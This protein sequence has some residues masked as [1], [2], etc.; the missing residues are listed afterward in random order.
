M[1]A[2]L[3]EEV[4]YNA[5]IGKEELFQRVRFADLHAASALLLQMWELKTCA[6]LCSGSCAQAALL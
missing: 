5:N 3:Q 4:V 1:D 2:S 6:H